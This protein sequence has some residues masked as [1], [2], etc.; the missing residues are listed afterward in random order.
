[1]FVQI[2]QGRTTDP[3]AVR[4][5]CEDWVQTVAPGARGWLGS[6]AGVTEDGMFVGLVRFESGE[7]ARANGVR[8]EQEQWWDGA[9]RL[10]ADGVVV[11]DCADVEV[12]GQGPSDTA[13]FVQIIQTRVRDREALR[14]F[15]SEEEGRA[16]REFRPDTIGG[17]FCVHP[18]GG[19]TVAVYFTSEE[20]AREGERKEMPPELK[21]WRDDEMSHY[22]GDAEFFDLRSPWTWT[23]DRRARRWPIPGLRKFSRAHHA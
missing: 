14:P 4:D 21:A 7:A 18:D 3:A 12:F 9:S 5:A 15:W 2:V 6:T 19:C 1:M 23:A 11:H 8:P 17:L 22:E 16:M 13:G 10:F 20:E